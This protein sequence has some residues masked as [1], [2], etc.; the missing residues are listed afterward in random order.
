VLVVGEREMQSKSVA[1][2][3]Y[4]H[5]DLKTIPLNE[6]LEKIGNESKNRG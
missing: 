5:G 6:C 3:H 1:V 2:R 4:I